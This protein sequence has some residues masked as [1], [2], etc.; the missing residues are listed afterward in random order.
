MGIHVQQPQPYDIVSNTI[1][2]A[3]IAGGAFE[4]NYEFRISEGTTR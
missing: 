1:Q 3:G 2:I 4:A